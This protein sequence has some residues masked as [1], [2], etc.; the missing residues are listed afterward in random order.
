MDD[1]GCFASIVVVSAIL[2]FG[3]GSCI[4]S[5]SESK[6]EFHAKEQEKKMNTNYLP[7]RADGPTRADY[8]HALEAEEAELKS[9]KDAKDN[10]NGVP[11]LELIKHISRKEGVIA[12]LKSVLK[13]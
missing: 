4:K 5:L 13:S 11:P 3:G 2:I 8:Q 6:N 1:F 9:L 12:W 7:T 10:Y